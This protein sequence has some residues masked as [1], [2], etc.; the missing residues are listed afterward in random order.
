M[1]TIASYCAGLSGRH[2]SCDWRAGCKFKRAFA[3]AAFLRKGEPRL[4]LTG[5]QSVCSAGEFT[6]P[7]LC[8]LRLGES[9]SATLNPLGYAPLGVRLGT[10]CGFGGMADEWKFMGQRLATDKRHR[11]D[12][13]EK[14]RACAV[15][16]GGQ[17]RVVECAFFLFFSS[18]LIFGSAGFN[19]KRRIFV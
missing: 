4:T 6:R 13:A 9:R 2:P 16:K 18:P 3:A 11:V 10:A 19:M 14:R 12:T 7:A 1:G 5:L 15:I 17:E 8:R